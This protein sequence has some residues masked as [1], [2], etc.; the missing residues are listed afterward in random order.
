MTL[1]ELL[2][3]V[4]LT[5][6]LGPVHVDA[7]WAD[8]TAAL[9]EPREVLRSRRRPRLFGFGDLEVFV[10]R[11]RRVRMVTVQTWTE[12]VEVPTYAGLF[13]G[14]P[15]EADVVAALD[16][17]GCAWEVDSALTFDGQRGLCVPATSATFVF[18]VPESGEPRLHAMGLPDNG[19]RCP[20]AT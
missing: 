14:E 15:T 18:V 9:G 6:R 4:A 3:S 11:C 12:T 17:A 1:T 2:A 16:R 10:C 20:T 7:S 19:H 5:A 13:P 8:V